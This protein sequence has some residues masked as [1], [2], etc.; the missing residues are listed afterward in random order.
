MCVNIELGE[1]VNLD[2]TLTGEFKTN[3]EIQKAIAKELETEN[4]K[5]VNINT[6]ETVEKLYG[7]PEVEFIKYAKE[8]PPR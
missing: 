1:V 4:V 7:M 3:L 5:V 2:Y 6:V 8:L